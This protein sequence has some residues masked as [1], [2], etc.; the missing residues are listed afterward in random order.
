VRLVLAL[1]LFLTAAC[2]AEPSRST[3]SEAGIDCKDYATCHSAL[4]DLRQAD[5]IM[6]RELDSAVARLRACEPQNSTKCYNLEHA[7]ELIQAEQ[8]T[9]LAWRNAHCDVF[10][11]SMED[12]SAEG[13]L[14]ASCRT[15][16]AKKRTAELQRMMST[17]P[18]DT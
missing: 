15:H 17:E 1:P 2:S 12:T 16:L 9:W 18:A 13:E 7:I 3:D 11:F 6:K 10:A 8:E 5:S 14:K 4:A